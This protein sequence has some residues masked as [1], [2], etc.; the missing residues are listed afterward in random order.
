MNLLRKI[1]SFVVLVVAV[2]VLVGVCMSSTMKPIWE[3]FKTAFSPFDFQKLVDAI[4]SFLLI[5]GTPVTLLM[6]GFIGL[7]IPSKRK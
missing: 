3:G 5:L 1:V 4:S 2:V 7:T 6:L